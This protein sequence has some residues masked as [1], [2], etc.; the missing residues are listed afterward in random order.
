MGGHLRLRHRRRRRQR[1]P[2]RVCSYGIVA[3]WRARAWTR[4]KGP[5]SHDAGRAEL[6]LHATLFGATQLSV[7]LRP[8][9][10]P[11]TTRGRCSAGALLPLRCTTN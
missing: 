11:R 9:R 2:R 6:S 4:R 10:R 3:R 1:G 8:T 7:D 5:S